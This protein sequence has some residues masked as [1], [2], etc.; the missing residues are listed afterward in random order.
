VTSFKDIELVS[1]GNGAAAAAVTAV[2]SERLDL[3]EDQDFESHAY[4]CGWT[5]GLPVVPPT[6]E[7]VSAMLA[8]AEV[9]PLHVVGVMLPGHGVA[10]A[11]AIAANAVMA[12]CEPATFRVVLASIRALLEPRFNLNGVQCTTSPATPG[13][14]V[15][16]PGVGELGFNAGHNCLG[17]GS[18]SNA[19]VGRAI[20]SCLLNIG[21]GIPGQTDMSTQ[22]STGKY[23]LCF[24][25]NEA[26][27]PWEPHH[28]ER[29]FPASTTCVTAFQVSMVG[30]ICDVGSKSAL[31]LLTSIAEALSST[32]TN[33]IQLGD[34]DL[35]VL[36][37]PEHAE[38]IARE[39]F[40]KDDVKRFLYQN[41]SVPASR[42]S[43]GILSYLLD[44]RRER[45]KQITPDTPIPI[46]DD[47]PDIQVAVAGG[48]GSQSVFMPGWGAGYSVCVEV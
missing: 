2:A 22:G 26:D 25:E 38:I 47:W 46:V 35:L 21:Y 31:S 3:P 4:A 28:V 7:R 34:G 17:P 41:A 12:G 14:M 40:T 27:S 32:N 42:F 16:G 15:N 20:R 30:N 5:D 10:T 33:T 48:A 45:F 37:C 39:G 11:E 23:T 8:A 24:A 44:F 1:S 6:P 13:V 19:T 43:E 36:L 29:G 9:D 18:R